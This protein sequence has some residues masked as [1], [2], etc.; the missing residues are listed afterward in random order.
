MKSQEADMKKHSVLA[1]LVLILVLATSC[2]NRPVEKTTFENVIYTK[3]PLNFQIG[4]LQSETCCYADEENMIFSVGTK[5]GNPEGIGVFTDYL[6]L[7]NYNNGEVTK[8]YDIKSKGYVMNAVPYEDGILYTDY[9]GNLGPTKWQIKFVNDKGIETFD[10]GTCNAYWGTPQIILMEG[11]PVYAWND[12]PDK[13]EKAYGINKIIDRKTVNIFKEKREWRGDVQLSGNKEKYFLTV[14]TGDGLY[15]LQKK[16]VV[17]D[18]DKILFT[19][20]TEDVII[21]SDITKDY[22]VMSMAKSMDEKYLT[23]LR[24]SDGKAYTEEIGRDMYRIKGLED[25]TCLFV[26][27]DFNL[28]QTDLDS[29]ERVDIPLPEEFLGTT[30]A[31][32]YFPINKDKC[33][34]HFGVKADELYYIM[35]KDQEE[36]KTF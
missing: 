22:V 15:D 18:L 36:I 31:A 5:N 14:E 1:I 2:R 13:G 30:H 24:L 29:W 27:Y 8:K 6:M 23:K 35:E 17:G 7:Y 32:A 10:E 12:F 4:N 9:E 20:E 21:S 26:D 25:N 33:I 16:V 28:F 19:Y 34:V 11:N 3:I